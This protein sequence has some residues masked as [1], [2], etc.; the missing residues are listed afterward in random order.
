[1]GQVLRIR[2]ERCFENGQS[3]A[4]G[5]AV[6]EGDARAESLRLVRKS[7]K[8]G[9]AL[10]R[11]CRGCVPAETQAGAESLLRETSATLAPM[12]DRDATRATISRLFAGRSD[13]RARHVA[14]TLAAQLLAGESGSN[15]LETERA[16]VARAARRLADLDESIRRW[17]LE[18]LSDDSVAEGM[19]RSWRVIRRLARG[20][21]L[22]EGSEASHLLR[23]RCARLSLQIA[24]FEEFLPK[25]VRGLRR[26]LRTVTQSLGDEHDLEMLAQR[27][28][29]H[30]HRVGSEAFVSAALDLCA[31]ARR[32]LRL[33]AAEALVERLS[34]RPKTLRRCLRRRRANAG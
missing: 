9:R 16:L 25:Q 18:E 14:E 4:A 22:D 29:L 30:R 8:I 32:R 19:V 27:L 12:R 28:S 23:R 6:A 33:K 11:L 20:A 26:S 13:E 3:A 5:H 1:M 2:L 24:A 21:W 15:E 7:T 34:I 10:L 31:K 17:R